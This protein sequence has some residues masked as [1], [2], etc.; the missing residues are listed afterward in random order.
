MGLFN[1]TICVPQIV[2]AALGGSLLKMQTEA[3]SLPPEVNMLVFAGLF[4]MAGAGC[5]AFIRTKKTA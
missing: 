5:V 2:A 4:L 3:G 1:G